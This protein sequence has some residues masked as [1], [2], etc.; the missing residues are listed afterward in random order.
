MDIS[1][2]T[3]NLNNACITIIVHHHLHLLFPLVQIQ[4]FHH[5]HIHLLFPFIPIQLLH[6]QLHLKHLQLMHHHVITKKSDKLIEHSY[7]SPNPITFNTTS[8]TT[9]TKGITI[10]SP[11][12]PE[13][14]D[15]LPVNLTNT[16]TLLPTTSTP[17]STSILNITNLINIF[18]PVDIN[19]NTLNTSN[20]SSS[21]SNLNI[22]NIEDNINN[23]NKIIT[24]TPYTTTTTATKSTY[25]TAT[26]GKMGTIINHNHNDNEVKMILLHYP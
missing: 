9:F 21:S 7:S 24:K 5:H 4:S 19:T 20:I 8:P 14:M 1:T 15:P 3:N 23:D 16:P 22:T 10:I 11:I 26:T 17:T 18:S 25:T 13:I 2:P 6:H 12:A